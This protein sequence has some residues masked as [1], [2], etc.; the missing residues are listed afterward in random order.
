MDATKMSFITWFSSSTHLKVDLSILD[1]FSRSGFGYAG[2]S[3]LEDVWD[4]LPI[5]RLKY[6]ALDDFY[7][8]CLGSRLEDFMEVV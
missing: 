8:V 1:M 6:N 2:F 7:E 4:D 3:D 5:S